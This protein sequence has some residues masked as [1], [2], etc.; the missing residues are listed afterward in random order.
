[1]KNK[2]LLFILVWLSFGAMANEKRVLEIVTLEYP[3]YIETR[4]DVVSGVAVTLV[5]HVFA[6]LQ[7]PIK[8]TVLPWARA[9][10]YIESGQADAIFTIFKTEQRERFADFS[11]Q[12][13]FRQN[14]SLI[15]MDNGPVDASQIE[16]RAFKQRTLCVV[17]KVSYGAIMDDA[18]NTNQFKSVIRQNSA[19]QCALMLSAGRVD[20]WVSNEFG[21]R[22]VIASLG[23]SQQLEIL[24]PPMQTTLSYIAFSKQNQHSELCQRFDL[25]LLKM[26]QDGSYFQLID[27]YFAALME[28]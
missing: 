18:I 25:E 10:N 16:Q 12:V 14:I 1:M 4:G 23:L 11:E 21:A 28:K 13:L 26:K 19:E 27:D 9:L 5:E 17:N 24:M 8:I 22:S 20:L 6:K 7:Q 15:Q 2:F 3:P